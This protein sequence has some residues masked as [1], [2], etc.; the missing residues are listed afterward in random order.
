MA[1]RRLFLAS[2]ALSGAFGLIAPAYAQDWPQRPV[3]ILVPYAAGGN[4]DVMARIVAQRL[5]EVLGQQFIVENRVGS[6]GALATEAVARSAPDGYTLLWA[7][8][9]PLAI[10]PALAKTPYDPVK[11]FAPITA[12]G[13]NPFVLLV[14][15][16]VPVT[17]VTEFIDHVRKQPGRM[18]YAVGAVGSVTHLAMAS[19][20]KRAGLEMTSVAYRGNAPALADVVAGHVPTMFSNLSDALP[21]A[22]AGTIRLLAVSS[23][24]RAPQI[25]NVPT[26]SE[27]GFPGYDMITWNGLMAPAGTP[28]AIVDRIAAE[29]AA[30]VKD[31]K[32]AERL[33]G[34][35]VDPLGNSPKEFAA[36]V[37]AD[38][39]QWADAV[40][41]VGI[42]SQ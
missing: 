28:A 31:A 18:N 30:G 8:L 16:T 38:V 33:V 13:T 27:S 34:I 3:K 24:Q 11:D 15:K 35:G 21:Q 1:T 14:N 17:T 32:F 6:N 19:F 25:P 39:V 40:T 23:T 37:A 36:M 26:V 9:P 20:L 10:Q 4:S 41:T 7:V 22:A 2:L 29:V 5:S 12:V 42:K